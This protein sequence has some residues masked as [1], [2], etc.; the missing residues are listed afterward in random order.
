M[1]LEPTHVHEVAAGS[2]LCILDAPTPVI[3]GAPF[4]DPAGFGVDLSLTDGTVGSTYTYFL[5]SSVNVTGP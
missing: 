1:G 2:D 3:S 4:R 5:E